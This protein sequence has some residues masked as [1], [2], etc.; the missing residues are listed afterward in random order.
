MHRRHPR[1]G[2]I[3]FETKNEIMRALALLRSVPGALAARDNPGALAGSGTNEN[4]STGCGRLIP[5]THSSVN[6]A[7]AE[8][9]FGAECVT[10][11]VLPVLIGRARLVARRLADLMLLSSMGESREDTHAHG[12]AGRCYHRAGY[13]RRLAP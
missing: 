5:L 9:I 7:Y 2:F 12:R 8:E 11:N 4:L 13:R 10:S 3:F 6:S 1:L